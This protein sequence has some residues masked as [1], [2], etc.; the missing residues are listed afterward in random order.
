MDVNFCPECDNILFIYTDTDNN[1]YNGCKYCKF[2]SLKKDLNNNK[3]TD[4]KDTNCVYNTQKLIGGLD[5]IKDNIYLKHDI[6]IPHI[7]S[8][9]NIKCLSETCKG[10]RTKIRY[11]NYD[12]DN[13]KYL[14]MC[15]HCDNKWTND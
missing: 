7:Y 8:N 12:N 13:M 10:K 11:I 4:I 5:L 3:S 9:K 6:T 15:D 2:N 1:I 14:Y